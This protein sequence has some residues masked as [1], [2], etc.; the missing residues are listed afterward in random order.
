MHTHTHTNTSARAPTHTRTQWR[1]RQR[2]RE[3]GRGCLQQALIEA[4]LKT[5]LHAPRR[6]S[7]YV[8]VARKETLGYR[9]RVWKGTRQQE[10]MEEV[11]GLGKR[12]ND[13]A[14]EKYT[15]LGE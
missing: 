2:Q 14:T 15:G 12:Q 4:R 5:C 1:M 11:W 10:E 6:T 3:R 7:T 13:V 8:P 9:G